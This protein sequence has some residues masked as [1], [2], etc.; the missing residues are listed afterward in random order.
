MTWETVA[1]IT[2]LRNDSCVCVAD[3]VFKSIRVLQGFWVER[4]QNTLVAKSQP[5]K[6]LCR[7]PNMKIIVSALKVFNLPELVP[8]GLGKTIGDLLIVTDPVNKTV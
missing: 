7:L 3:V 5:I 4:H 8:S 1:G 6:A 2:Y